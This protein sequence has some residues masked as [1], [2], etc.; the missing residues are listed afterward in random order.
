MRSLA[1]RAAATS[2]VRRLDLGKFHIKLTPNFLITTANTTKHK[3]VIAT[4]AS[5]DSQNPNRDMSQGK[6]KN[7]G[8]VGRTYQNV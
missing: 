4:E 8:S 1:V 6:A 3:A 7:I 5:R 2:D